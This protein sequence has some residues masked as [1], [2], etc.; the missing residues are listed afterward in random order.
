MGETFPLSTSPLS[1]DGKNT[2][3]PSKS[4]TDPTGPLASSPEAGFRPFSM[5]RL[6]GERGGVQYCEE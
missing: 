5:T 6:K 3:S 1:R 2:A 4:P